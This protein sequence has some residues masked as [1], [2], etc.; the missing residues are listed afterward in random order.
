MK[1]Y[2][3]LIRF[4]Y[5]DVSVFNVFPTKKNTQ[6]LDPVITHCE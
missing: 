6:V 3:C 1:N 4:L 5:N 2:D